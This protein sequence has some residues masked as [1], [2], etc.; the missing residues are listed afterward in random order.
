MCTYTLKGNTSLKVFKNHL[1]C[2]FSN[3]ENHFG[4]DG[5]FQN[6]IQ[7]HLKWLQLLKIE[8]SSKGKGFFI[9]RLNRINSNY[10]CMMMNI[11]E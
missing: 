6:Y 5:P 8:I 2:L 4:C 11:A 10:S 3:M 7:L 9:L 1:K